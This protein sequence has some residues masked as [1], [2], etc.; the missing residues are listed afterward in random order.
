MARLWIQERGLGGGGVSPSMKSMRGIGIYSD[1]T[2]LK[3]FVAR[4]YVVWMILI[5]AFL[6][7]TCKPL[8][9]NDLVLNE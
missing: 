1:W 4:E 7:Y 5:V 9:R 2:K 8:G 3:Y 6:R